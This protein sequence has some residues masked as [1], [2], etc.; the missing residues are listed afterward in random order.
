MKNKYQSYIKLL[1]ETL[2]AGP[3]DQ[4]EKLAE[5]FLDAWKNKKTVYLCGNG[6]S[7]GN[8]I[9]LANDFNYGIDKKNGVGLRIDALPANSSIVTCIA[10]DEGYDKIFSQ[11]L[12]VK[13]N[14]GDVL[15]VLSGSGN[16]PNVV[17][18][19]KVGNELGMKTYA[20]LGYSGGKCKD[21]AQNPIHFAVND[22][23]ISEDLQLIIGHM[24]MQWLCEKGND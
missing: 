3:I 23:Q 10:N 6:G 2:N 22:M 4:I 12:R 16:S 21:L 9:H 13:A 15:V 1:H 20:I 7:A 14:N 18:A 24:I 19:L 17:D 11:Q 5:A 8:A